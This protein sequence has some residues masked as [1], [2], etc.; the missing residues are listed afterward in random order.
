MFRKKPKVRE[1][2][3]IP[4]SLA[5]LGLRVTPN[6][7]LRRI[8]N[9]ELPYE[10][11]QRNDFG[12]NE[13]HKV[14][15]M[16][17]VYDIVDERLQKLGMERL[18]IPL[19]TKEDEPH[20]EILVSS[21]LRTNAKRVVVFMP[22]GS[23]LGVWGDRVLT[24][25]TLH[26]GSME[27]S[28]RRAQ[29][30]RYSVVICNA[31]E[32]F[33]VPSQKRAMRLFETRSFGSRTETI[34]GN[35]TPQEHFRYV[36]EEVIKPAPAAKVVVLAHLFGTECA[37]SYFD[38]NWNDWADHLTA[39][40][41]AKTQHTAADT[42]NKAFRW[43]MANRAVNYEQALDDQDSSTEKVSNYA[44][45]KA[46]FGCVTFS[47]ECRF[48]DEVVAAALPFYFEFFEKME[49]EGALTSY[50]AGESEEEEDEISGEVD[51]EVEEVAVDSGLG[52]S[53]W[54]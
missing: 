39:L 33:Y 47:A 23:R 16:K 9:P 18:R 14:A 41:L 53:G 38:A 20:T 45:G 51:V 49:K 31:G 52:G 29:E 54:E 4:S 22:D 27:D 15:V 42:N 37:V 34:P 32:L 11:F 24:T 19:G 30:A 46:G 28:V 2:F 3:I 8:K 50:E 43:F 35:A 36:M 21:D 5:E 1:P 26:A 17:C 40:G 12:Y 48:M 7:E 25:W 6:D 13:A 44:A 10:Y